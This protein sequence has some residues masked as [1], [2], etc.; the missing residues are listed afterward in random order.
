MFARLLL[1]AGILF[2]CA[3][4]APAETRTIELKNVDNTAAKSVLREVLGDRKGIAI[5]FQ[6][7]AERTLQVS[8]QTKDVDEVARIIKLVE[9]TALAQGPGG[10]APVEDPAG[11]AA[12]PAA[13]T[14][15]LPA[16]PA[17]SPRGGT[18]PVRVSP[19]GPGKAVEGVTRVHRIFH[20]RGSAA[21]VAHAVRPLFPDAGIAVESVSNTLILLA[22]EGD[23]MIIEALL[24]EIDVAPARV[25]ISLVVAEIPAEADWQPTGSFAEER[26]RLEEIARKSRGGILR[27][28][29][30]ATLNNQIATVQFSDEVSIVVGG[31]RFGPRGDFQAQMQR[32]QIGTMFVFTP[33]AEA[34]GGVTM[35]AAFEMSRFLPSPAPAVPVAPPAAT[36]PTAATPADGVKRFTEAPSA[37]PVAPPPPKQSTTVR[38]TILIPKDKA[39]AISDFA[40]KDENSPTRLVLLLGAAVN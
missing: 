24:R 27:R 7:G 10:L 8:G 17:T 18:G 2:L 5:V 34:D 37:P 19:L 30:A 21:D 20:P 25:R 3:G 35:E 39:V 12:P 1:P 14:E 28:I 16:A 32:E 38:T 4:S 6:P 31:S 9:E 26:V 11:P 36:T 23:L 22:P 13:P 33:R 29:E 15:A 40:K